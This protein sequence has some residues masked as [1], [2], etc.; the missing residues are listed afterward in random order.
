[1]KM[2]KHLLATALSLALLIS[3]LFVPLNV[4]ALD[5]TEVDIM[6]YITD[7]ML[8]DTGAV[9]VEAFGPTP[10]PAQYNYHKEEMSA[11]LHFSMSTFNGQ[12]WSYG[13]DPVS[14]FNLTTPIDADGYVKTIRD[15]GFKMLIVTAKHHDGF[16]IW[17][18]A[19][20]DYDIAETQ[21]GKNGGDVLAEVSAACTKYGIKMGLYL[22]PWDMNNP[23][24][25]YYDAAG[26]PT[27]AENDVL[28]YNDYYVN[29]LNEI[30]GNDKY[31]CNGK[32]TEI[33]LDGAKGSG[34]DAQEYDFDRFIETMY[35]HEGEDLLLFG[36]K[37][38]TIMWIGNENGIANEETWAMGNGTHYEGDKYHTVTANGTQVPYSNTNCF[39]G[40]K[41]GQYWLVPEADAR[42]TSGWF[43][44]EDKKTPKTL[45]ELK[46]MYLK[47]VGH[48]AVLLLNVPLN[49]EGTLDKAIAD[50]LLEFSSNV[51]GSFHQNNLLEDSGVTISASEVKDNDV[52]FKPS[53]VA[54]SDDSTYWAAKGGSETAALHIDF[55]KTVAFDAVTLEEDIRFGQRIESF[56]IEY[57]NNVGEWVEFSSGT[58]IGGKRVALEKPVQTSELKITFNSRQLNGVYGA[59]VISSVGVYKATADFSVGSAAP[60]GIDEYDS[61]NTDVF[62]ANDWTTVENAAVIGG[63]YLEGTAGKEM[64]V[65]FNGSYAWLVGEIGTEAATIS[66]SIDGGAAQNITLKGD[67]VEQLARI[68]ETGTLNSGNHTMKIT[69]V[70]GKARIDGLYVLDNDSVGMLDFEYPMYN[71]D[72]DMYLDVKVVRK[73]GSKG[74]ISAIVQ[75]NP[76]SAV[77]SSYHTTEGIKVEFLDGETEK[78]VT[79]RTKRYTET[80]GTL[81]FSLKVVSDTDT[82]V[83][84]GFNNPSYIFIADAEGYDGD[85]LQELIVEKLPDNTSYHLGDKLDL[86]GLRVLGKYITGDERELQPDQYTVD[87]KTFTNIGAVPVR[88]TSAFDN[89]SADFSVMV[90]AKGDIDKNGVI[91]AVDLSKLRLENSLSG[92]FDNNGVVNEY[93]YDLLNQHILGVISLS[94]IE[95]GAMSEIKDFSGEFS[96]N[97]IIIENLPKSQVFVIEYQNGT[98]Q[99]RTEITENSVY[100]TKKGC[101]Y[102]IECSGNDVPHVLATEKLDADLY[103][104]YSVINVTN[105]TWTAVGDSITYDKSFYYNGVI[106]ATGLTG[107]AYGLRGSTL[108]ANEYSRL[109]INKAFGTSDA[110]TSIVERI[111]NDTMN[112]ADV[113]TVFGGTNDWYYGSYLG[114]LKD[115]GGDFDNTTVYGALQIICETVLAKENSPRLILVAPS[116]ANR[117]RSSKTYYKISYEEIIGAFYDVA[118]LYD[119]EI[120]NM[121][122]KSGINESNYTTMLSDGVHP[123][124]EGAKLLSAAMAKALMLPDTINNEKLTQT[125]NLEL[126]YGDYH[127]FSGAKK[128]SLDETNGALTVNGNE[129]YATDITTNPI[130]VMVDDTL[131]MVTVKKAKLN[132]VLVDGQSN[133]RGTAGELDSVNPI[134]PNK[135]DGYM[136]VDGA[137]TDMKTYVDTKVAAISDNSSIGFYPALAAEWYELTGEKTVIIH[138]GYDGAPIS[139]WSSR[140]YTNSAV[141]EIE[142]AIAAISADSNFEIVSAGYY[143]LQGESNMILEANTSGFQDYE[144]Y[145]T[146]GQYIDAYLP[147]HNAY[148]TALEK[149]GVTAFGG[150]LAARS[151]DCTNGLNTV[152]EYAGARAAQIYLANNYDNIVMVSNIADSWNQAATDAYTF[153][154]TAGKQVSVARVKDLF[155]TAPVHYAQSGFNI[156]G[157]DAADGMKKALDGATVTDFVLY[158]QDGTTRYDEND[159]IF[160]SDNMRRVDT[161]NTFESNAAQ[162]VAVPTV[163]YGKASNMTITAKTLKGAAVTGVIENSG[164]IADVTKITEPLIIT[165]TVNGISKNYRILGKDNKESDLLSFAESFGEQIGNPLFK[166]D[167]KN[168]SITSSGTLPVGWQFGNYGDNAISWNR[169]GKS[170]S[171]QD[172]VIDI[173]GITK[174]GI[175]VSGDGY[176]TV[177]GTKDLGTKDYVATATI[178]YLT[179][180]DEG[181]YIK[182]FNN[183]ADT[184]LS[185]KGNSMTC[186]YFYGPKKSDGSTYAT[187]KAGDKTYTCTD[188]LDSAVKQ[189]SRLDL[190]FY[191]YKGT[192]YY[193]INGVLVGSAVQTERETTGDV[194]GFSAWD[195]AMVI[196]DFSVYA[197]GEPTEEE[198]GIDAEIKSL[199]AQKGT[200]IYKSNFAA[201]NTTSNGNLPAGWQMGL[202]S[203]NNNLDWNRGGNYASVADKQTDAAGATNRGIVFAGN[204]GAST[205]FGTTALGTKNYVATA[206]MYYLEGI[207][208]TPYF[209]FFNNVQNTALNTADNRADILRIYGSKANGATG[210]NDIK[211]R[212]YNAE[213]NGYQETSVANSTGYVSGGIMPYTKVTMTVISY[214]GTSYYYMNDLLITSIEQADRGAKNDDVVG[215]SA[216]YCRNIITDFSVYSL[217]ELSEDTVKDPIADSI[218]A[219]LGESLYVSDFVNDTDMGSTNGTL[220]AGWQYGTCENNN[221]IDWNRGRNSAR[222]TLKQIDESGTNKKGIYFTSNYGT[223]IVFGTTPIATKNYVAK[224]TL[225]YLSGKTNVAANAP[226]FQIFNGVKNTTLSAADNGADIMRIYAAFEN[227]TA[228]KNEMHYNGQYH[229][230]PQSYISG[231]VMPYTKIDIALYSYEGYN[232][233]YINDSFVGKLEKTARDTEGDVIGLSA[234]YSDLLLTDFTVT[235]LTDKSA[236]ASPLIYGG[237]SILKSDVAE[238]L[239]EQAMRVYY[240]YQL[241]ENGKIVAD[242]SEYALLERGIIVSADALD[243]EMVRGGDNVITLSKTTDFDKCW[244]KDDN[245]TYIYSNYFIGFSLDDTRTLKYRGYIVL[246]DGS[247]DG[248]VIYT[249]I[250]S[251]SISTISAT[252]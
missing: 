121:W 30:L 203:N 77:Q 63:S 162:I 118:A 149:S 79:V 23:S 180:Y 231:G 112:N 124:T 46:E 4:T 117:N 250:T 27:T 49:N 6:N 167:I 184:N 51:N 223:S 168:Q 108:A 100:V 245:G 207:G 135:G 208:D 157:L 178:Y 174:R 76:G 221:N 71:V 29:Q 97:Y 218:G 132:L 22:S 243:T 240:S 165:V 206:T 87:V 101:T 83:V 222:V 251:N 53:N 109:D 137:L 32:F 171:V 90:Y 73:G 43:W 140:G 176:S 153:T 113:W 233:Y 213:K 59:P 156:I 235:E 159:V 36:T 64:T 66:V 199:G 186:F 131:Y 224:A 84:A 196:T 249:D 19:Y 151:R 154:S 61:A 95:S 9:D 164:Y 216:W 210:S 92:D 187:F 106:S 74:K 82:P 139:F 150:I 12:E 130:P 242:G 204:Y 18:S 173:N 169:N 247:A 8:S 81:T 56:K 163:I 122:E 68:F 248:L 129:I 141:T 45:D 125:Q 104:A 219:A 34:A 145:T 220:P 69:V 160:V 10:S 72:E 7:S 75:D 217:V 5:E 161:Q 41:N 246:D 158:G 170:A 114:E 146:P 237:A 60:E 155:A 183:V 86:T 239:G 185:A 94:T 227:G 13:D 11:F 181:P 225:Y 133:A 116:Y 33:W 26:N 234:W 195:S 212:I 201:E 54:D 38:K 188:Y 147:I 52:K 226:Y 127:T 25:G 24:Y 88:V 236:A 148:I 152:S 126:T 241:T 134:T 3:A 115:K 39:T 107:K 128:V 48:N 20:T 244:I 198:T 89:K 31:G 228:G 189:Y 28:D 110:Y 205:V 202:C 21:Y 197:F 144:I 40:A 2:F 105:S 93:D 1:M 177:I 214:N 50:R 123:T 37:N 190:T 143:W 102:K 103:T 211:T 67:N 80:T 252:H 200:A 62:K 47:S 215:F 192:N 44:G 193:F 14:T 91:D 15:A 175:V 119:V 98:E 136:W 209:Q 17:P 142:N 78:I 138:K 238:S 166:A 230:G 182:F 16:C 172:K 111:V 58:T 232:Y 70:S 57:K 194:V 42:I 55:G 35:T 65:S 85:Y 179:S 229:S 191:S 96:A 120:L 99:G